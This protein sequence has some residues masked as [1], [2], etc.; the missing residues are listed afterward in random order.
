MRVMDSATKKK[1]KPIVERI[2]QLMKEKNDLDDEI[3]ELVEE[4][5]EKCDVQPKVT[6]QLAKETNWNEVDRT[7]QRLLEEELDD[8]RTAL[9]L[10]ADTPLGQGVTD[11]IKKKGALETTH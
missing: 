3:K 7:R 1:L 8:A 6:R 2:A 5:Q 10:L 11:S 4:A 9:G